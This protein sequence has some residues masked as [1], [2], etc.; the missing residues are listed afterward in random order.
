[1]EEVSGRARRRRDDG[2]SQTGT[3]DIELTYARTPETKLGKV[4]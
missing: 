1:M 2:S 3:N 4:M